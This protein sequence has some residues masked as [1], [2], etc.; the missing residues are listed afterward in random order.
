M[1]TKAEQIKANFRE[2]VS[3]KTTKAIMA[4]VPVTA[5]MVISA[6]A[7]E[8]DDVSGS[9]NGMDVSAISN[10]FTS[11]FQSM[12]TNSISMIS[13]MVPI[14]LTLA[15]VLFLVKKAMSWFK[16]MAK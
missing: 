16:G 9:Y 13:A 2:F 12:V 14:A 11:G 10:A 15:G 3:S 5:M 4:G 8:F 1:M 6:C 7:S